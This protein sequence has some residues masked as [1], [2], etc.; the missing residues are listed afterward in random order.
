MRT[1]PAG[2]RA[3]IKTT[4]YLLAL[5]SLL[6][7][8]TI[9]VASADDGANGIQELKNRA[10]EEL[11]QGNSKNA[12]ILYDEIGFRYMDEGDWDNGPDHYV[13][14]AECYEEAEEYESAANSYSLVGDCYYEKN[15]F[16][17]ALKHYQQAQ[18]AAEIHRHSNPDYDDLWIAEKI[19]ECQSAAREADMMVRLLM[20]GILLAVAKFSAKASLGSAY[21]PVGKKGILLIACVYLVIGIMAGVVVQLVGAT[22]VSDRLMATLFDFGITFAIFQVTLSVLLGVFGFLTINKW[23]QGKDVSDKTFLAMV[24]PCPVCVATVFISTTSLVIAGVEAID[25]GLLV[26]GAF[27]VSIMGI[28]FLLRRLKPRRN[29]TTLGVIMVFFALVYAVTVLFAPAYLEASRMSI[30]RDFPLGDMVPVFLTVLIIV[31]M[32]FIMKR[33]GVGEKQCQG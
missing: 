19:A 21:S 27:S 4:V 20:I 18:A 3:A 15:D 24:I 12:A 28:A 13:L 6:V 2:N 7:L 9:Q 32:G 26:G 22:L 14:S 1:G 10:E 17:N 23:K 25:A 8:V 5:V 33:I 30:E 31:A 16:D 29:P 11:A